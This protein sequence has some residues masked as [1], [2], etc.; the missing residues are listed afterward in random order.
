MLEVMLTQFSRELAKNPNIPSV[1][2]DVLAKNRDFEIRGHVAANP[3][4]SI[5]CNSR[6]IGD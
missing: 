2:L 3:N 6:G 5:S 1:V 4:T